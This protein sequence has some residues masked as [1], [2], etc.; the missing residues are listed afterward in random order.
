MIKFINKTI[1]TILSWFF[2]V[3]NSDGKTANLFNLHVSFNNELG[4]YLTDSNGRALYYY[5]QDRV[6]TLIS[7]PISNCNEEFL[8]IWQIFYEDRIKISAP[9][10][11]VS[12]SVLV[13]QEGVKQLC[14]KGHPLYYY[15]NDFKPGD[16]K[17]EGFSNEFFTLKIN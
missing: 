12:F 4:N 11:R 13:R 3:F 16:C 14:Y 15:I 2:I 10:K 6:G 8:G 9:L 5:K 1:K 17:G 7:N